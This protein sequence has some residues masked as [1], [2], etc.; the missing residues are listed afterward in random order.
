MFR[1]DELPGAVL[2]RVAASHI[3]VGTFQWAAAHEDRAALEALADHTRRRHYPGFEEGSHL[4]FFHAVMERQAALVAKWLQVGFIHGVM[5]TDNMALSGETIDYGP[6]AFLDRYDPAAVFSSID[7]QGRYAYSAQPPIARWNL[8]RLAEAMI[9]LLHEDGKKAVEL[10]NEALHQF[11][12]IFQNYW[13][14]GMRA[15]LGLSNEE[16]DD[17]VLVQQLLD[18]MHANQQDFTGNFRSLST[19][20]ALD[21]PAFPDPAF[22]AWHAAWKARL[23]RQADGPTEILHRMQSHNPRVIPRNQKVEEALNAAT[24]H[25]DFSSFHRLLAAITQP[26]AGNGDDE[27]TTPPPVGSPRYQTFCGT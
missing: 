25:G 20:A 8:A 26:F 16:A 13:L 5:N 22:A 9:P 23:D 10:A 4:D 17:R 24:L 21:R 3:R 7:H 15:K 27:F 12:G 14:D 18:W 6:C 11:E 2:T 1:N 19:A